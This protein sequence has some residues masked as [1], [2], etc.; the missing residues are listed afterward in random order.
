[1]M[2]L[3][4]ISAYHSSVSRQAN[5]L[6]K[7][8]IGCRSDDGLVAVPVTPYLMNVTGFLLV[9]QKPMPFSIAV[10]HRKVKFYVSYSGNVREYLYEV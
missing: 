6:F 10:R 3:F 5:L 2:C 7:S 4:P 1:M 9:S 8:G